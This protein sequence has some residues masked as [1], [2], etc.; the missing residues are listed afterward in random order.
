MPDVLL[1]EV[2]RA[3]NRAAKQVLASRPGAF[4][5]A[6]EAGHTL[7]FVLTN[8]EG[9]RLVW[10][11]TKHRVGQGMDKA[12][13][14][15]ILEDAL[16]AFDEWLELAGQARRLSSALLATPRGAPTAQGTPEENVLATFA[17]A[18]DEVRGYRAAARQIFD[19]LQRPASPSTP[20]AGA[21]PAEG[22]IPFL[23][24]TRAQEAVEQ[25][26]RG[27]G[28]SHADVFLRLRERKRT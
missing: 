17:Q 21:E 25:L 3:Q 4:N 11:V 20:E 12:D 9:V 16:G 28:R 1:P 10:E 14:R 5:T 15:Q 6:H 27:E 2:S 24:P 7:Q 23:D 22:T 19:A 18:E 13:S 8:F 26:E